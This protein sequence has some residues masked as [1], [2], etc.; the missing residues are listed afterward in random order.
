MIIGQV[1]INGVL[2]SS[3]RFPEGQLTHE[4]VKGMLTAMA[5]DEQLFS[6]GR[7]EIRVHHQGGLERL[8]A[9]LL[10]RENRPQPGERTG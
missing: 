10:G 5:F 1:L 4:E 9:A 8:M 2:Y 7:L 6:L 3:H